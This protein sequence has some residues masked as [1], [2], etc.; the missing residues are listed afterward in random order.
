M[1]FLL[2][3]CY[4][5]LRHSDYKID[6]TIRNYSDVEE[7]KRVM[8]ERP[9]KLSLNELFMAARTYEP[10][11]DDYNEVF[12]VAVRMFPEDATANLNAANTAMSKGDMKAAERYLAKAGNSPE[13]EYAR[14]IYK[15]LNKDYVGAAAIFESVKGSVPQ[16]KAT[17]DELR[18]YDLIK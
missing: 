6:Y 2:H 8:K 16:A 4:P 9:Q 12:E 3:N 17:L 10:G 18:E 1:R 13:A 7:I 11:S 15:A 5:A 14:G